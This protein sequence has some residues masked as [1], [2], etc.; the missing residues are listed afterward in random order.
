MNQPQ[1]DEKTE[2]MEVQMNNADIVQDSQ[3]YFFD[4][5]IEKLH[6]LREQEIVQKYYQKCNTKKKCAYKNCL[7]ITQEIYDKL[8]ADYEVKQLQEDMLRVE[9]A[10]RLRESSGQKPNFVDKLL[11]FTRD[12]NMNAEQSILQFGNESLNFEAK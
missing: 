9:L 10:K 8:C 6:H 4:N 3:K 12:K 7:V 11:M 1:T 2:S 5:K